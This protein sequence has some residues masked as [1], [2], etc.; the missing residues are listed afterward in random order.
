[1]RLNIRHAS[2]SQGYISIDVGGIEGTYTIYP[3][4][5][6]RN[7]TNLDPTFLSCRDIVNKTIGKAIRTEGRLV[8]TIKGYNIIIRKDGRRYSINYIKGNVADIINNITRLMLRSVYTDDS[9]EG[10]DQLDDYLTRCM[11][12]PVE[13]AYVI[14]NRVPYKFFNGNK[15]EECRLNVAQIGPENFAIELNNAYW[16]DMTLKQLR[17]F[18]NSYLKDSKVGKFY[19]ISPEELIY[20]LSETRISESQAAVVKAFMLQNRQSDVVERRSMELLQ[21]MGK[22]YEQVTIH[23]FTNSERNEP[24]EAMY[25]RGKLTDWIIADN[26]MKR[27]VQDVSTYMLYVN[28][29]SNREPSPIIALNKLSV[30]EGTQIIGPIC[31]DNMMSGAS[32]GDQYAA[33]AMAVMNDHVLGTYVST[34]RSYLQTLSDENNNSMKPCRIDW[35][36]V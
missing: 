8:L 1:M 23:N 26:G 30:P 11:N 20:I 25:V 24:T 22:N 7:S 15:L 5:Y 34:V 29:D 18:V 17:Q 33:R 14:E 32:K 3:N 10:Q 21:S 27:G 16:Y 28:E 13:L 31:I 12:M 6:R 4:R 35:D 36:A 19:A 9:L 2:D